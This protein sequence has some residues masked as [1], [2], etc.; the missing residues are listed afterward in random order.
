M[1][2]IFFSWGLPI[3]LVLL[4]QS[5]ASRGLLTDVVAPEISGSLIEGAAYP[6][7]EAEEKP[8]L[9]Y[10]W[11]SWCGIC[12]AMQGSI[13][14]VAQDHRVISVALRSGNA[15][16]IRGYMEAQGFHL[17]TVADEEGKQGEA[18]GVRGVPALFFIDRSG[19]IRTATTGFTSEPGIRF[20]LWW[21]ARS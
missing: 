3:L 14:R 9:V 5:V 8:V 13:S 12:K 11:A 19:R 15:S 17:P 16:D 7:L 10:F 18:F 21:L 2:R 6:G 20:R 4:I 1:V